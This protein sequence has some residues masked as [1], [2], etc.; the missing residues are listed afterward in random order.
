MWKLGEECFKKEELA[1]C[2]KVIESMST[3]F[4]RITHQLQKRGGHWSLSNFP[5]ESRSFIVVGGGEKVSRGNSF[6]AFC[7]EGEQR[8]GATAEGGCV[9]KSSDAILL[10]IDDG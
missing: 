10:A 5:D 8:D 1:S 7:C 2:A 9:G 6:D 4:K 3:L